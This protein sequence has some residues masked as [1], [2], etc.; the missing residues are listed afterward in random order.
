M[1]MKTKVSVLA[2]ALVLGGA[3][4]APVAVLADG[5]TSNNIVGYNQFAT[6]QGKFDIA[7]APFEAIA[8]GYK[9]NDIICGFKGVNYDKQ[10]DFKKTASQIQIP[11]ADDQ[12]TV[13]YYLNDGY[14]ALNDDYK[15]GWCDSAGNYINNVEVTPG[16]AFWVKDVAGSGS[17]NIAGAVADEDEVTIE[18]PKG[19]NLRGSPFPAACSINDTTKM[20]VENIDSEYGDGIAFLKT[21]PQLQIPSDGGYRVVWYLNDGYDALNDNYKA[22]WC[23]S[24]GNIVDATIIVGQ[25]FW[26]KGPAN[27]FTLKFYNPTK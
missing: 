8:G 13:Y 26:V 7:S 22:G 27:G 21:A 3:T 5:L 16:A 18:C 10:G 4:L 12:Y 17:L 11:N 25:G 14:D 23:D 6:E 19:F 2:G 15:A 20:T 9:M 24:A 1:N